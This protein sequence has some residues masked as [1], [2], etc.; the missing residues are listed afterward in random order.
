[1]RLIYHPDAEAELIEAARYYEGR[2]ATLG[3]QFLDDADRAVSIILRLLNVGES[4]SKTYGVTSCL[5][6]HT[7]FTIEISPTTFVFLLSNI[8]ADTLLTG[9]IAS[10]NE[11]IV[12]RQHPFL[13]KPI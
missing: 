4:S 12:G 10:Q 8:T 9:G 7:Q 3:I 2:V 11:M 5:A 13:Y 1:M 6:F